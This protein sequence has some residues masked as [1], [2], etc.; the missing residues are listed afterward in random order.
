MKRKGYK[1][2][3]MWQRTRMKREGEKEDSVDGYS[4]LFRAR[5]VWKFYFRNE[6]HLSERSLQGTQGWR[7]PH[8]GQNVGRRSDC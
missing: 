1:Y 4:I 6:K 3:K 8:R 2:G 7:I 5:R